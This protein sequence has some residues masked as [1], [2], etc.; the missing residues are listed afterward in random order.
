MLCVYVVLLQACK[1]VGGLKQLM[2][3]ALLFAAV[4]S[5]GH[6]EQVS[7]RQ[8]LLEIP[9]VLEWADKTEIQAVRST[10]WWLA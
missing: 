3:D 5:V 2:P 7:L 9:C 1:F 8:F 6:N 10:T 4:T